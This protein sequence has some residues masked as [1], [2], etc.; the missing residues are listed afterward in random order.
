MSYNNSYPR[1]HEA[2]ELIDLQVTALQRSIPQH[3]IRPNRKS[4]Y[5]LSEKERQAVKKSVWYILQRGYARSSA[6]AFTSE[7]FKC[8]KE[9]VVD[10]LSHLFPNGYFQNLDAAKL[11][12][13]VRRER[14]ATEQE[15]EEA[16]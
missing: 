9:L 15:A 13:H 1:I 3:F 2:Q 7:E 10:C 14:D 8:S 11:A 5:V 6:A 12:L 4:S 16:T